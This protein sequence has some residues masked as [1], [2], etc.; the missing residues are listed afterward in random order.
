MAQLGFF[1][2]PPYAA[3]VIWTHVKRVAPTRDLWRTLYRLGYH[4]APRRL[5]HFL[6][7]FLFRF[8]WTWILR[9]SRTWAWCRARWRSSSTGLSGTTRGSDRRWPG[10]WDKG[11]LVSTSSV[12][13]NVC[14]MCAAIGIWAV[15]ATGLKLGM[16]EGFHQEKVLPNIWAS[17]PTPQGTES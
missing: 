14:C 10:D 15:G 1:F 4:A 13:G 8:F 2:L 16:E 5:F 3:A 7:D 12:Q 11:G 17:L 9:P 6:K